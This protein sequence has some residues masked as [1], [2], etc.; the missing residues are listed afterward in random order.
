MNDG[1]SIFVDC[2]T[3]TMELVKYL[4]NKKITIV[5]NSWRVL[6]EIKD[7]SKIKVIMAPGEYDVI[8]EGVLSSSTISFI[9]QY[10]VDKAFISTQGVDEHFDVC[11]PMDYDAQVKRSIMNCAK[12]AILLV[13]HTKFNQ[14]YFA[15]H[16]NL[17]DFDVVI[18][19]CGMD[20]AI[21]VS[22][23]VLVKNDLRKIAYA[24]GLSK[25]TILNMNE[26][27]GMALLTVLLLFIGLFA[28][29]VEMASGM[30]IH[31]FSI[32]IV[33]LNGMRLI[34]FQQKIDDHQVYNQQNKVAL[35]M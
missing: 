31:E 11:V 8:S 20:V 1:D 16:G 15:K 7:F 30:F 19:D 6:S 27:I 3:T 22:D 28:G 35:D 24:L 26:N 23:I 29:Y 18:T 13:D 32:L 25:K 5:T 17:K 12:H 21:E 9:Q 33:I 4:Q 10:R 14:S 2:G 34:K